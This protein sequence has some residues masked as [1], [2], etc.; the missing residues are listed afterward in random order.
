M[1]DRIDLHEHRLARELRAAAQHVE[2][3]PGN[4]LAVMTNGRRRQPR[5]RRATGFV[6]VATIGG[7]T[8]LGVQQLARTGDSGIAI[9][10][11][12]TASTAPTSTPDV[13][14]P[15]SEAPVTATAPSAEAAAYAAAVEVESNIEWTVVEPDSASAVV[16]G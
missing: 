6:L 14:V 15:T 3:S 16:P 1:N 12:A 8:A 11:P 2:L 9:D 13:S 4:E 5:R 10:E 7:G